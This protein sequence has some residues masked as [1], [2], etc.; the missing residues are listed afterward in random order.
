MTTSTDKDWFSLIPKAEL[1]LHLEGAI[2][3][4]TLQTL[5]ASHTN[6]APSLKSLR[7]RFQYRD[8]SHFIET[9]I[10]QHQF[11]KTY[12]D[13]TL[14]AEAF[15]QRLLAQNILYAETFCSP[16]D[17]ASRGLSAGRI[18]HA[19]RA[20]LDRVPE[21]DVALIPDLVRDYGPL[22]GART[23]EEIAEVANETGVIGIGIGGSEQAHPPE[24]F[25]PVFERARALGLKTSAHA[26]E[27]AGAS[28]VLG[29]LT[30]LKVDRIGHGTRAVED[31]RLL[32]L[33]VSSQT[34][35][36][37]CPVSN[38]CTGVIP[39]LQAHPI[40]RFIALG[41][42]VTVNTDDPTM[43]NTSLAHELRSLHHQLDF[44][45]QELKQ[46]VLGALRDAWL[47][48]NARQEKITRFNAAFESFSHLEPAATS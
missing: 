48:D 9:W 4:E 20:G 40:R 18:L 47:G 3:L 1:H 19:I 41:V 28:S 16:P 12:D 46:L 25:A 35:I 29:A 31:P 13:L 15:A 38:V 27:A 37:L 45:P 5:I 8:F 43:F 24:P 22:Q 44:T 2:P 6:R 23:L 14:I 10:W 36:E 34:P 21:V 11:I 32:D 39:S 30:A 26:G 33:L 7:E 17:F 42:P